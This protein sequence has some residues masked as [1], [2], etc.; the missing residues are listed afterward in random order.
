[1]GYIDAKD[2]NVGAVSLPGV[3]QSLSEAINFNKQES[4]GVQVFSLVPA[5]NEIPAKVYTKLNF[6]EEFTVGYTKGLMYNSDNQRFYV[7]GDVSRILIIP[8][9]CL[10]FGSSINPN[11][12][13][14]ADVRC[15]IRPY[16]Y[17]RDTPDTEHA[18]SSHT[19]QRDRYIVNNA[20][21]DFVGAFPFSPSYDVDSFDLRM[22]VQGINDNE[23]AHLNT[24][25]NK[26][27]NMTFLTLYNGK[28]A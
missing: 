26:S 19:Q 11:T 18:Y 22:Y 28:K 13:F 12:T 6:S 17:N 4:V 27:S 10:A 3:I 21:F 8:N 1:M 23:S 25:A 16:Y 7:R 20:N 2:I 9:I 14:P 15:Y 24:S 5:N